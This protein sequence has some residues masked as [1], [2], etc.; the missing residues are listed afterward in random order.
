MSGFVSIVN[1]NGAPVDRDQLDSLT[2][3]LQFRGPDAQDVWVCDQ[4]GFGHAMLRTTEDGSREH[5]PCSLNGTTWLTGDVRVDGRNELV[6]KLE[7]AG[8]TVPGLVNDAELIL[9]A[10]ET[11]GAALIDHLLGDFSFAIWDGRRRHFF[12]ARDHLG[13]KPFF[14]AI[15]GKQLLVSNT[16]VCLR[17]HP[18]IPDELNDHAVGDF[19]LFGSNCDPSSTTFVAIKRLP[20]GHSLSWSPGGEPRVDRYWALPRYEE[21]RL[22]RRRD[23]VERFQTI[24]ASAVSDRLRTDRARIHMSGGLDSTAIAATAKSLR[25]KHQEPLKLEALT[26]VFDKSFHDEERGF[27]QLVADFLD[28]P[29]EYLSGDDYRLFDE[30]SARISRF[31]EPV[32]ALVRP[33]FFDALNQQT[34]ARCRVVLSG[35]DGDALL[36]GS[37]SRHLLSQARQGQVGSMAVDAFHYFQAKQ[38]LLRA[39]QRRLFLAP[40]GDL[41]LPNLPRWLETGFVQRTGLSHRWASVFAGH[42][43]G[44]GSRDAA[45]RA[46]ILPTWFPILEGRDA[47]VTGVPVEHRHPLLDL[48][49]VE[50]GL[51]LPAIPWC[52]DKHILREAAKGLIP[53]PART[54]PKSALGGDPMPRAIHLWLA[55]SKNLPLPHPTLARYI[56]VKSLPRVIDDLGTTGYWFSLRALI[57]NFWLYSV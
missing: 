43:E 21:L 40:R 37:W 6:R 3:T 22:P 53:E 54:R 57:L 18:L 27:S 41:N 49:M 10:Y 23:Y 36:M 20:G 44:S 9:Y 26:V 45:Y 51:S 34:D 19:L 32:D 30:G 29:I 50:F 15:V 46:M 16:L 1:L 39:I 7:A 24:L 11:W 42:A 48:R 2:S 33:S 5:Q 25:E 52:I 4:I 38:K 14:Y 17:A 13:V 28:M 8:Q 47:G 31:P 35:Y 55:A 12:C 56:D